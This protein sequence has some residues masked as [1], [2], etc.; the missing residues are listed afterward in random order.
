MNDPA[1]PLPASASAARYPDCEGDAG[2]RHIRLSVTV[3]LDGAAV[4]R[5]HTRYLGVD[6]MLLDDDLVGLAG[7]TGLEVE[8]RLPV[9]LDEPDSVHRVSAVPARLRDGGVWLAFHTLPGPTRRVLDRL[10]RELPQHAPEPLGP[11]RRARFARS[12]WG[13]GD[14]QTASARGSR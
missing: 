6:G 12:P 14:R 11:A 9:P 1:A 5:A 7:S 4:F 3:L 8:F 10:R 13:G 2:H